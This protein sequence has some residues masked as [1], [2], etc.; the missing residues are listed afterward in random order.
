MKV[1][2]LSVIAAS[3]MVGQ[4]SFACG[5]AVWGVANPCLTNS[6]EVDGNQ[7][8]ATGSDIKPGQSTSSAKDTTPEGQNASVNHLTAAGPTNPGTWG[9]ADPIVAKK[10]EAA[11]TQTFNRFDSVPSG[12][13]Y[14]GPPNREISS[15]GNGAGVVDAPVHNTEGKPTTSAATTGVIQSANLD[16]GTHASGNSV[17]IIRGEH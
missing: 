7:V 1:I 11:D 12:P 3:M 16:G 13:S 4:I 2:Y 5:G 14:L 8:A 17:R 15:Q 9:V 6:S 10:E